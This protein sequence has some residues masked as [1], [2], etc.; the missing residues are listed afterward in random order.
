MKLLID[1][2]VAHVK[3]ASANP[4]FIHHKWFVEYHLEIVEKIAFELC[5]IYAEADRDFVRLLVWLHDYGKI[6]DFDNQ[7]TMTL[8]GGRRKLLE[9]GFNED[10]ATKAIDAIEVIDRKNWDELN[11]APIE[12]KIVSSADAASHH[13]GPFMSLWWYENA[14]KDFRELMSDN[15]KK[16]DKDW[17]RKMILP[18]ARKFFEARRSFI[19]ELN[20]NLPDR[21]L[22]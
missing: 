21:Y 8:S 15:I 20:G 18:E 19:L 17:N 16:S 22:K 12:I 11:D 7:Y 10:V 3:E 4:D 5:E 9:L 2:F 6:L 1:N 14:E 13:T